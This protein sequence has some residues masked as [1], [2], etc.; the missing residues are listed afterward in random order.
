M[1]EFELVWVY[2]GVAITSFELLDQH[3]YKDVK[4]SYDESK[5]RYD[6]RPFVYQDMP[7][8][9]L[10]DLISYITDMARSINISPYAYNDLVKSLV[11]YG[12][13]SE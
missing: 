9:F 12:I 5:T 7:S 13:I 11:K 4:H 3:T 8:F 2:D 1:K 10:W 6:H